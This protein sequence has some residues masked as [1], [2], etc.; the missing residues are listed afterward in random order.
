[1][2]YFNSFNLNF[3]ILS[4]TGILHPSLV[5][6]NVMLSKAVLVMIFLLQIAYPP[7]ADTVLDDKLNCL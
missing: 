1:M 4:N 2:Y 7:L 3:L 6:T 5:S